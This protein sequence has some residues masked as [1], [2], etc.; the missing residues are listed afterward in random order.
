MI[1]SLNGATDR[2]AFQI[3]RAL[4]VDLASNLTTDSQTTKDSRTIDFDLGIV[5]TLALDGG[6]QYTATANLNQDVN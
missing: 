6:C 1:F 5:T 3:A 2:L 4:N